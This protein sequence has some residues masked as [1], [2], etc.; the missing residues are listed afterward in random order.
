MHYSKRVCC[1]LGFGVS[2]LPDSYPG[3]CLELSPWQ[4]H[5]GFG[6]L[7][8]VFAASWGFGMSNLPDTYLGIGLELSP[9]QDHM[10]F[11]LLFYEN[12]FKLHGIPN[13]IISEIDPLSL[14]EFW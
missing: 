11:S 1:H 8:R 9:W 5:V 7:S 2:N 3:I 14:T 10:E 6:Y 4:F 13:S 12:I